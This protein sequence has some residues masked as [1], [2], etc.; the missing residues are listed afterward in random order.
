MDVKTIKKNYDVASTFT[1]LYKAIVN[2]CA[3]GTFSNV[4]KILLLLTL[5]VAY[6]VFMK[7]IEEYNI[8]EAKKLSLEEQEDLRKYL[9][10]INKNNDDNVVTDLEEGF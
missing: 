6:K 1:K 4:V 3:G 8:R 7:K 10:E 5:G 2:V 9:D